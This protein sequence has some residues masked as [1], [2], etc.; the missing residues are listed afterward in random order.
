MP[1]NDYRQDVDFGAI[2]QDI[3]RRT[4]FGYN[5]GLGSQAPVG[6]Y[7]SQQPAQPPA[8]RQ[9]PNWG[10]SPNYGF[11]GTNYPGG[12]Q[13]S[14]SQAGG[15]TVTGNAG[16]GSASGSITAPAKS[17]LLGRN[18]GITQNVSSGSFNTDSSVNIRF[19]DVSSGNV[20]TSGG[21]ILGSGAQQDKRTQNAIVSGSGNVDYK[22]DAS[23]GAGGTSGSAT[24]GAGGPGGP[25][26]AGASATVPQKRAKT[27]GKVAGQVSDTPEAARKRAM[28]AAARASATATGGAGGPGGEAKTGSA[29][30]GRGGDITGGDVKTGP[31]IDFGSPSFSSPAGPAG[32]TNIASGNRKIVQQG[33]GPQ[34]ADMSDTQTTTTTK[35]T[36][37]NNKTAPAG[38]PP[39]KSGAQKT[40][41]PA[42]KAPAK[43]AAAPAKKT[44][45]RK[46]GAKPK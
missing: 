33:T 7:P 8:M 41:A 11:S 14:F 25:A 6:D 38:A 9:G 43:K 17:R 22:L 30:G 34:T 12:G 45:P 18:R 46:S 35:S 29:S 24:G 40:T 15:G 23:G 10:G 21:D 39:R 31:L 3:N 26:S 5:T 36:T 13:G 32:P 44:A 37:T 27:G 19:G 2:Q 42:K 4:R 28:R 20:N 16:G 1:T